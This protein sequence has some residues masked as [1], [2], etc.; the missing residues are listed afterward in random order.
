MYSLG[1]IAAATALADRADTPVSSKQDEYEGLAAA[2]RRLARVD[3]DEVALATLIATRVLGRDA[4]ALDSR[5]AG[6]AYLRSTPDGFQ[7]VVNP[8]AADVRFHVAHELGEWA[9]RTI[10]GFGGTDEEREIAANHIGAAILMPSSALRRVHASVGEK[11]ADLAAHFG[12]SQTS[13]VLR[14]AEV[15]GDERAVVTRTGNVIVRTRGAFAWVDVPVV[16]V[17]R[18]HVRWPGLAKAKLRGGIDDGR[19][20][21]RVK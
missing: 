15:H 8:R 5:I 7:I 20:A 4:V 19:I 2:V 21:L 3:D 10:A 6:T 16:D 14:L 13:I 12:V 17:A 9:L 18:G 11:P 1:S